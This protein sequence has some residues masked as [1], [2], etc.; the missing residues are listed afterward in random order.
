[1]TLASVAHERLVA[2]RAVVDVGERR[3]VEERRAQ[4]PGCGSA[5][6]VAQP[7]L[8]VDLPGRRA[9]TRRCPC[10]AC[11][12]GVIDGDEPTLA[13][14]YQTPLG[15]SDFRHRPVARASVSED[16]PPRRVP[17]QRD[18]QLRRRVLRGGEDLGQGGVRRARGTRRSPSSPAGGRAA[19]SASVTGR[20][21]GR[22]RPQRDPG[23]RRRSGR[24]AGSPTGPECGKF[25]PRKF[26]SRGT[27]MICPERVGLGA[28]QTRTSCSCGSEHAT[29]GEVG[30]GAARGRP[31]GQARGRR[32][33][34]AAATQH[35]RGP[36]LR[37]SRGLLGRHGSVGNTDEG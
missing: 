24:P 31:A 15:I 19:M 11:V 14:S 18:D 36:D 27:T 1:M 16:A 29:S 37:R 34:R 23:R 21:T 3:R 17:H 8:G 13:S 6:S 2:H 10:V 12:A 4:L 30:R 9:G 22:L 32:R 7:E 33:R 20:S 28:A 26:G 35:A 5:S 25:D